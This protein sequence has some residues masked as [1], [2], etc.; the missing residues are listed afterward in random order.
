LGNFSLAA[1]YRGRAAHQSA[2]VWSDSSRTNAFASTAN[3]QF[4]IRARGGVGINTNDPGANALLV[5]GSARVATNLSIG[6]NLAVS[7]TITGAIS[8]LTASSLTTTN[9]VPIELKPGNTT[10]F[11]V[12]PQGTANLA[13]TNPL[14]M[15]TYVG[16]GHNIIGGFNSHFV[17]S[18]V[19][20]ATIAGGGRLVVSNASDGAYTNFNQVL[21]HFGTVSGGTGNSADGLMATVS[22]GSGNWSGGHWA[23]IGGGLDNMIMDPTNIPPDAL[24]I[25]TI[26]G[27]FLNQI[28]N[29]PGG[30]IGGGSVN[31]ITNSNDLTID[32]LPWP[33]AIAGGA[34]N[35]STNAGGSFIGGG[36]ENT[37]NGEHGVVAGGANNI[38]GEKAS[39]PGGLNNEASGIGSFAAGVNAKATN[40]YSF[41]WG[42]DPTVDTESAADSSFTVN[43]PGGS[44]FVTGAMGSQPVG[45]T[46]AANATAWDTLSDSN[47][48]TA[49]T[50]VDHRETLRKIAALQVTSWR[51][52]HDPKRR[53]IGPMAQDFRA[54]FGLGHDD[55]HISTLDT[56]GVTLSAIK[57]LVTE[58]EE[59]DA[60]L[61]EREA[62]IRTLETQVQVLRSQAGL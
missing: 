2:F 26:A 50:P 18:G 59:Q 16:T 6:G 1:G 54:A 58:I 13:L 21:D 51:Y 24:E 49:V 33:S 47:A 7:G 35:I 40:D 12:R 32:N 45:V 52:K 8:N 3:H 29:A 28:L 11:T 48:K 61:A 57:G 55:K 39:V 62:Q 46:L 60:V 19:V 31:L 23:T 22:G 4:L 5:N 38:A 36:S 10:G 41:V 27:G 44:T 43:A 42:G 17:G 53:Y 34:Q 25:S 30:T 56:D 20:G 15:T 37:V 14:E 9:N